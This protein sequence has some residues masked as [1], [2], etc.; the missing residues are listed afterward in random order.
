V[1]RSRLA[2]VLRARGGLP[3]LG[4]RR[5]RV[6]RRLRAGF[7]IDLGGSWEPIGVRPDLAAFGKA[8]ANGYPLAA[9]TGTD[10]LRADAASVFVT[11]SFWTEAVPMAAALA[12]IRKL[13]DTHAVDH[14][15]VMGERLRQ[16]LERQAAAHGLRI[17]QTGP[18][19]MPI[20]LFE[21]DADT[22][23]GAPFVEQALERGVYLHHLHTL[24]VSASH[25][26][27]D[28]DRTLDA[29]D[30]AFAEVARRAPS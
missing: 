4:R 13:R 15:R 7:R 3:D 8:I 14:M 28:V 9:V 29:T 30:A 21:D 2:A 1:A 26:E 17:R 24:F 19:Q 25:T 16:G 10:R 20:V 12:T 22:A 11:G 5:Q 6:R 23:L 18:P 27:L